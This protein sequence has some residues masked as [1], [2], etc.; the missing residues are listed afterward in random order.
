MI[1]ADACMGRWLRSD[2]NFSVSNPTKERRQ[3]IL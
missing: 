1:L 3:P 2:F